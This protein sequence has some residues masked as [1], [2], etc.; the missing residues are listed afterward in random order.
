[1][2]EA[3]LALGTNLGD[4]E[5]YLARA[6]AQLEE[7]EGICLGQLSRV[8]TSKAWGVTDQPDFLNICVQIETDLVPL[9]L[10]DVC[11]RIER[12]LG[13]EVRERWG[14]REIDIDIL[15]MDGVDM[16]TPALTIPH[17]RMVERRFVMD[18]LADIA[19]DREIDGIRVA[20]LARHL[21]ADPG[22]LGCAP[23]TVATERLGALRAQD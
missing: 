14:P 20:D 15:L 6:L 12:E 13:R 17:A 3:F 10:L 16:D 23:D 18:P 8:Y 19:P 21:R 9:D 22:A 2:A 11:K 4:R 5:D 7:A 1:M